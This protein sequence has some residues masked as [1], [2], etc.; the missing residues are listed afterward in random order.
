MMNTK[1]AVDFLLKNAT[2]PHVVHY[3]TVGPSHGDPGGY[4]VVGDACSC[5]A[6]NGYTATGIKNGVKCDCGATEH[7]CKVVEA[8]GVLRQS[9]EPAGECKVDIGTDNV[10]QSGNRPSSR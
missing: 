5:V 2:R 7:N 4:P 10:C 9:T 3:I 8:I 6:H 1:Q